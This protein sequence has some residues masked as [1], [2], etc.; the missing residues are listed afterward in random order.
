MNCKSQ[1]ILVT[2]VRIYPISLIIPNNL[3]AVKMLNSVGTTYN[4]NR[5]I[6]LN[7]LLVITYLFN[8]TSPQLNKNPK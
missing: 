1:F 5:L 8:I 3:P 6:H 2:L 4:E 7:I